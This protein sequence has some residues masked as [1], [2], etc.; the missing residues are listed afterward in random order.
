MNLL[1]KFCSAVIDASDALGASMQGVDVRTH[2]AN[3]Y[4]H[5]DGIVAARLAG[6]SPPAGDAGQVADQDDADLDWGLI[7]P[8]SV[9]L[10]SAIPSVRAHAYDLDDEIQEAHWRDLDDANRSVEL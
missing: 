2:R 1:Q 7:A 8:V 3:L 4:G 10:N 6:G 9:A 5:P